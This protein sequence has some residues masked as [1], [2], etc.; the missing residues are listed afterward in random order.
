MDIHDSAAPTL[1][2]DE[3]APENWN[4]VS[5]WREQTLIPGLTMFDIE[6]EPRPTVTDNVTLTLKVRM[7]NVELT[8]P[9][10]LG[11]LQDTEIVA[12]QEDSKASCLHRFCSECIQKCL[13]VGRKECPSCRIHVPSRR[14][15]RYDTNF[16]AVISKIYPNLD[17]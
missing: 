17:E 3:V 7:L 12:S 5:E 4:P 2:P 11:I 8:C 10:C 16:D 15:L 9:I 6:R 13:R 14:S 1:P